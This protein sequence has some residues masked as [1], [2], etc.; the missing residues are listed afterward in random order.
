MEPSA[1][2]L[3]APSVAWQFEAVHPVAG[4]TCSPPPLSAYQCV[5]ANVLTPAYTAPAVRT[6]SAA[7]MMAF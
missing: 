3:V 7:T 1:D 6:V 2:R 5:P 4:H